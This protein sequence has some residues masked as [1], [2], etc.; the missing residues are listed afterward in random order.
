MIWVPI[1]VQGIQKWSLLQDVYTALS[2]ENMQESRNKICGILPLRHHAC[3]LTVTFYCPEGISQCHL[4]T[5]KTHLITYLIT[6][7]KKK[8]LLVFRKVHSWDFKRYV[9]PLRITDPWDGLRVRRTS[10]LVAVDWMN[11]SSTSLLCELD[12]L[13]LFLQQK[14]I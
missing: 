13:Y 1:L 11:A 6:F 2:L 12:L 8:N 5:V 10:I 7:T 3:D 14:H 4:Y 9:F